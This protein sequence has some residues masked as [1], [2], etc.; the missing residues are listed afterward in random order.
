[1]KRLPPS[2]HRDLIA[3]DLPEAAEHEPREEKLY[4]EEE[5]NV[6]RNLTQSM[7]LPNVIG[8]TPTMKSFFAELLK[9]KQ[10]GTRTPS[11]LEKTPP[12]GNLPRGMQKFTMRRD[13]DKDDE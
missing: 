3:G 10:G 4:T 2:D 9:H 12:S 1:M 6:A 11:A 7:G 5:L 13:W 8:M